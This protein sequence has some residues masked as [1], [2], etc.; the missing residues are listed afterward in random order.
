MILKECSAPDK[1]LSEQRK[2]MIEKIMKVSRKGETR[3]ITIY[4]NLIEAASA[5]KI[6]GSSIDSIFFSISINLEMIEV[7]DK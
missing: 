7:V 4:K 1:I 6:F 5:A 2:T 3:A